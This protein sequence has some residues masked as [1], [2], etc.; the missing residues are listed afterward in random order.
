[1]P[2]T[3][4]QNDVMISQQDEMVDAL[5]EI[6]TCLTRVFIGTCVCGGLLTLIVAVLVLRT[7]IGR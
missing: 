5:T 2:T 7:A 3:K 6:A 1:M 4:N